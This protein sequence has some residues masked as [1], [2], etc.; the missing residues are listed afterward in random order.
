MSFWADLYRLHW[1]FFF[2][3]YLSFLLQSFTYTLVELVY[4]GAEYLYIH[5][6][7]GYR[8]PYSVFNLLDELSKILLVN[9]GDDRNRPILRFDT[10]A[11]LQTSLTFRRCSNES[12]T[13]SSTIPGIP[14][15]TRVRNL[16]F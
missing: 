6:C 11:V 2:S 13:L 9:V 4:M 15:D 16:L 8:V 12:M 10:I 1:V 3:V 7:I 5:N 14:L